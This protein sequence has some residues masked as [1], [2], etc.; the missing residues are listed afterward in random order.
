MANAIRDGLTSP[1]EFDRNDD[2]AKVTDGLFVIAWAIGRLADKVENLGGQGRHEGR[3]MTIPASR[4]GLL[5]AR[6]RARPARSWAYR[7]GPGLLVIYDPTGHPT[8][9]GAVRRTPPA[10]TD[11][12]ASPT[13]R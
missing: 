11:F 5:P 13:R 9:T 8:S 2:V 1:D 3:A 4:G 12:I 6:Q 10:P 7:L